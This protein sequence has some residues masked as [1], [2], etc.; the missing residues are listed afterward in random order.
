MQP[1]QDFYDI[2]YV[3]GSNI[4]VIIE[5]V[6]GTFAQIKTSDDHYCAQA[7]A[8]SQDLKNVVIDD[9]KVKIDDR[10]VGTLSACLKTQDPKYCCTEDHN[11]P[12]TCP[13]S[14]FPPEYYSDLK[15]VCPTAY[16]YAYDD[17]SSTFACQGNG[18]PSPD[19][20][21]TFC[22]GGEAD[23][24]ITLV[25]KC[26]RNVWPGIYGQGVIPEDGGLKLMPG[27]EKNITVPFSWVAGRV[28][29]RT[30]C[31]GEGEQFF[32]DVGACGTSFQ[33]KG[34]TG[35]VPVSLAEITLAKNEN[36]QDFYDISF[37]DGSSIPMSMEPI[38]GT[39]KKLTDN[40]YEC[41]KAGECSGDLK[42]TVPEIMKY[43]KNGVVLGTYSACSAT[44]DPKLCCAGEYNTPDKCK[45]EDF[46]PEYYKDLK[47]VCPTSYMYAYDDKTSTFTC[48]GNGRLSPDYKITFCTEDGI[49]L[50]CKT[51]KKRR[52]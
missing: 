50:S 14:D 1:E 11:T 44:N 30:N 39:Y 27:A 2:S 35:E 17:Q 29:P 41:A 49:G 42:D 21:V 28:W 19:Y 13:A 23:V 46:P 6:Q 16:M 9:L 5:P 15:A 48:R 47:A 26:K 38:E 33:C 43:K 20:T 7:G 36:D 37:V 22:P 4:P 31:K 10:V 3:D 24:T 32:C 45:G 8:C 12:E 52:K 51:A 25:N 18:K 34:K 40:K